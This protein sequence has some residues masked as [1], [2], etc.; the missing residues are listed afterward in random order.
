MNC[1]QSHVYEKCDCLVFFH[2][3]FDF[4]FSW[5]GRIFK[6]QTLSPKGYLMDGTEEA[7]VPCWQKL[8]LGPPSPHV[9]LVGR[10]PLFLP[11]DPFR[12]M[13]MSLLC[14]LSATQRGLWSPT[15]CGT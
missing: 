7:H 12:V 5:I 10:S 13:V 6:N 11:C 1:S 15:M 2:F 8:P 4:S 9:V 3:Y 14:Y